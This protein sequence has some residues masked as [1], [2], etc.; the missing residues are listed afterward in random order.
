LRRG[1][2]EGSRAAARGPVD[3][4]DPSCRH[5]MPSLHERVWHAIRRHALLAPGARV[6]AA[7]SGGSDSVALLH[8]LH[9][10]SR[11]HVAAGPSAGPGGVDAGGFTLAGIAHLNHLLRG[12]ASDADEQF[13]R[14]LAAELGLRFESARVDVAAIAAEER[15]SIEVAA[16]NARYAFLREAAARCDA[17]EVALG[18]TMNDQA[19]TYLLRLLRGA[20][21]AGLAGMSPRRGLFVRPLLEIPR[22]DLRA[23]LGERGL[24]YRE[25]PS[26]A[27]VSIPRNRIR[28]ELLP[29][30]T[31][32]FTPSVVEVL[33]R[34][35]RLAR[36]DEEWMAGQAEQAAALISARGS[37]GEVVLDAPALLALP[38]ALAL[39]VVRK[40]LAD[41]AG[42]R[43]WGLEQAEYVLALASGLHEKTSGAD[44][45][46]VRVERIGVNVVLTG[47]GTRR[48]PQVD[49]WRYALPV[50]GSLRI[51]EANC[52]IDA[53]VEN[54]AEWPA[55]AGFHFPPDL[56]A[57]D[58][59]ATGG[60]LFVRSRTP[61][62]SLQP[63][64]LGGRKKL[65]DVLVDRKVLRPDRDRVPIVVDAGDRILW[66]AG[67]V[68]AEDAKV[69]D[70]TQRVVIL[71]LRRPSQLGDSA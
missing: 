49:A 2:Q 35:A 9:D 17:G 15:V 26:N 37:A 51:P 32:R 24:T 61:G 6:V 53:R 41:T 3:F 29:M 7:V 46:G 45:P 70:R 14:G 52:Q 30:L 1:P 12:A 10:L 67:H 33:A 8:L 50:P 4:S 47:R 36:K 64:G 39:R 16:H 63:L 13:C 19:E 48:D 5:P 21:S 69:T 65:Q 20:G 25:D 28:H 27:D 18:H 40:A 57:I 59:D 66:V 68:L 23:W 22:E 55:D 54:R 34:N 43:F 42:L 11:G 44:L 62:D 31:E 38:P 58:A 56:A 60:G 71:E